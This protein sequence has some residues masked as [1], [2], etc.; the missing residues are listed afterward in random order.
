MRVK[1]IKKLIELNEK[2]FFYPKLKRAYSSL[3]NED[4]LILDIGTNSGQSIDFFLGISSRYYIIGYEPNS[5]LYNGLV[6]RYNSFTNIK[7]YNKGISD[8]NGVMC[9]QVNVLDLTSSFEDL[10][11]NSEYLKTKSKVLGL[12]ATEDIVR[13]TQEVEVSTLDEQIKI[14][15]LDK[16]EVLK[17]DVEGHELNC[18]KGLS[19][20]NASK[21]RFLQIEQHEDD[22][23]LNKVKFS[24]IH[25][26]INN[27]G[28]IEICKIKHGFGD[29]YEIIFQNSCYSQ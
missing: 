5:D 25:T 9:L 8:I 19:L 3:L 2:I 12:D 24:Q 28:F 26:I 22:M 6:K 15:N 29:F 21:I 7:I 10:N 27:L 1:I 13:E 20:E 23:Y 14:L 4:G 11:F 16:I 17:I 18:L